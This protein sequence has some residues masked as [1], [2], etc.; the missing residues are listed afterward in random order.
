M[1]PQ[2][3]SKFKQDWIL[4]EEYLS[5]LKPHA[6]SERH[7]ECSICCTDF[8]IGNIGIG[9]MPPQKKKTS[10]TLGMQNQSVSAWILY[11]SNINYL[12]FFLYL[13]FY[14]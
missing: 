12:P 13:Y 7:A 6:T 14:D 1:P 5:W 9:A 8:D 4:K 10:R 3:A 11:S 2:R